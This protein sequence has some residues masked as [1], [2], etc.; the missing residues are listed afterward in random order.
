MTGEISSDGTDLRRPIPLVIEGNFKFSSEYQVILNMHTYY[1]NSTYINIIMII[2]Q[3]F[4]QTKR[5]LM[6]GMC[7]GAVLTLERSSPIRKDIYTVRSTA[8]PTVQGCI[9]GI[10]PVDHEDENLRGLAVF[11]GASDIRQ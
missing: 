9:E 7:G 8:S 6:D 2:L 5:L 4:C 10:V 11:V 1:D 3:I